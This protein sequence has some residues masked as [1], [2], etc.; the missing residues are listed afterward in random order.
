MSHFQR[1]LT[2]LSNEGKKRK[3]WSKELHLRRDILSDIKIAKRGDAG[4]HCQKTGSQEVPVKIWVTRVQDKSSDK[5]IVR[6]KGEN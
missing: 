1:Y 6:T 3:L 2:S 4:T 5:R